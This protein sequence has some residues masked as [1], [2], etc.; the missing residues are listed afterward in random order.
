MQIRD[1]IKELRRVRA[2][3]LVPN[4]WNWRT[5][6]VPQRNA[7]RGILAEVGFADALLARELPDGRLEIIDGHLRAE[8]TPDAL[9]PV[10]VLDVDEDEARKIL[11]THDPLTSLAEFDDEQLHDLIE[12]CQFKN[13]QLTAMVAQLEA[14]I[15]QATQDLAAPTERPEPPIPTAYQVVVE[16]DS[17]TQQQE[18]YEQM[19][20]QGFR[21]RVVTL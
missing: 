4:P 5:H 19:H 13:P 14:E 8:T 11:L 21:C 6:P 1:R 10:L 3:E 2:S 9:V 20:G 18:V 7:M 17:E 15:E 16:C 12:A